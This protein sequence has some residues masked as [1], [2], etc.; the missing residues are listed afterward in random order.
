MYWSIWSFNN[1]QRTPKKPYKNRHRIALRNEPRRAQSLC[2]APL[3]AKK[4]CGTG[5]DTPQNQRLAP[6]TLKQ[7]VAQVLVLCWIF[8]P[9]FPTLAYRPIPYQNTTKYLL[10]DLNHQVTMTPSHQMRLECVRVI[11]QILHKIT[12]HL[13]RRST[14]MCVAKFKFSRH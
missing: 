9:L 2:L 8:R 5:N 13:L 7:G 6:H 14:R 12:K 4:A 10:S 1:A 3:A 11:I